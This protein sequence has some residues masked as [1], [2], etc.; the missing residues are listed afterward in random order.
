MRIGLLLRLFPLVLGL[1]ACQAKSQTDEDLKFDTKELVQSDLQA[2]KKID[3]R[4]AQKFDAENNQTFS[5]VFGGTTQAD[6]Q[7]YLDDRV[8]YYLAPS[9]LKSFSIYPKEFKFQQWN[10]EIEIYGRGLSEGGKVTNAI[11]VGTGLWLHSLADE[12]PVYLTRGSETIEVKSTRVGIVTL[13]SGY[14]P[15][16]KADGKIWYTPSLHRQAVLMHEARHSDCTGG[17]SAH[18]I[19]VLRSSKN[20]RQT[21]EELTGSCGHLHSECPAGHELAGIFACDSEPWGAYSIGYIY[22]KALAPTLT[23]VERA[24]LDASLVDDRS[25]LLFDVQKMFS[26]ELGP[27]DMSSSGLAP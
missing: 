26:G 24:M 7:K 3:V 22:E 1:L 25:R 19:E 15:G 17:I 10:A 27:P 4:V 20:S 18:D 5:L 14:K 12:T 6:I 21:A 23:G 13:G 16:F 9:E 8:H 2:M 11:N